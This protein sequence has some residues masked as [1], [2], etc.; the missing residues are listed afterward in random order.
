MTH[1]AFVSEGG[2]VGGGTG[3]L[4]RCGL[5]VNLGENATQSFP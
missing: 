3:M 4:V 2:R 1:A 5:Y